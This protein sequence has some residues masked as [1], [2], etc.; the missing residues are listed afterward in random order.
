MISELLMA[1]VS[2]N[3]TFVYT[4]LLLIALIAG[5]WAAMIRNGG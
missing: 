4:M 5:L 2:T 1:P 3:A